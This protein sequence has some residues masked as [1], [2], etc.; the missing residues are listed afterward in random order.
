MCFTCPLQLDWQN[1]ASNGEARVQPA[2]HAGAEETPER[3][4]PFGARLQR[5]DDQETPGVSSHL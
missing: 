4:P 3:V 5:P 2:V 1:E